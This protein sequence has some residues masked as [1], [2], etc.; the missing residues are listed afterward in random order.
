MAR[1]V[2]SIWLPQL[3]LD[4]RVRLGDPRTEDIFAITAEIKNASRLPHLSPLALSAAL[5][6]GISGTDAPPVRPQLLA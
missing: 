4:R 2:M 6:R 3:P 1:R 5:R